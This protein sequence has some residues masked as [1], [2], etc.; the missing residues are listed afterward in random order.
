MVVHTLTLDTGLP[1]AMREDRILTGDDIVTTAD[2]GSDLS[3]GSDRSG[4][5]LDAE[6]SEAQIL[7]Q[8][9]ALVSDSVVRH[10]LTTFRNRVMVAIDEE[11]TDYLAHHGFNDPYAQR[12]AEELDR[13]FSREFVDKL[14]EEFAYDNL[15]EVVSRLYPLEI[16]VRQLH[17]R[18]PTFEVLR[19]RIK[20]MIQDLEESLKETEL[21]VK[22]SS[23][24]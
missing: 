13:R 21:P 7:A 1:S 19:S 20:H 15:I 12:V 4:V 16:H 10:A 18:S 3:L 2:G 9:S 23:V 8:L 11:L 22:K 14:H 24:A 5:A 17:F 6:A